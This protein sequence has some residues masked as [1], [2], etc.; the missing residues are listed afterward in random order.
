MLHV[1]LH[2]SECHVDDVSL[3]PFAVKH[4]MWLYNRLPNQITGLTP[5]EML[6]NVKTNHCNLL[7]SHV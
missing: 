7:R 6:T 5:M 3:W 1:A 4:A 2:W